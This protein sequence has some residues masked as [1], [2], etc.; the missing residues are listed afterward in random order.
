[1][2]QLLLFVSLLTLGSS[3]HANNIQISNVSLAS[4]NTTQGFYIIEFDL[5]WEN[6][7]RTST[8]ESNW[9]AAW[10]YVKFTPKNERNWQHA[11]LHY[12]NG[13]NDGHSVPAGATYRTANN[14]Y[15][16]TTRGVGVFIYRDAD[17]FGPVNFQNVQLRWDY[18]SNGL[19]AADVVEVSVQAIEMVYVRQGAFRLGDGLGDHGQFEAGNTGLPYT[20]NSESAITL[21]G[22]AIGNL[23][24]NNNVGMN[25]ADDFDY[26][27]TQT[28]PAAFPKGYNAFYCMKYE[29]SSGDYANFVSML[30]INSYTNRY[31]NC[32][33]Q[34][35]PLDAP[36]FPPGD[37][38]LAAD[39]PWRAV[40]CLSWGDVA[41][42][43]DWT[44]LRPMS[45]LEY[46]K[47]ARGPVEPVAG[48]LAWGNT[49]WSKN[50]TYTIEGEGPD[51]IIV[52]G[53]YE[54]VG[55][56]DPIGLLNGFQG[57]FTV[58][59]GIFA[60]SAINKT[61]QE[62]GASY[63]GIMEMT[64]NALEYVI[65]VGD[66]DT[67]DFTGR[68]GDGELQASSNASFSLLTDWAFVNADGI[69]YR[70]T[71]VS[72]REHANV[73]YMDR[74]EPWFGIRGCRTAP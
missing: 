70:E 24:N 1:M 53:L 17:G 69:G 74:S 67:R 19:G 27:T 73:G 3:L 9:D 41:A 12:V 16:T 15:G 6:S 22:T 43:L 39:H 60:A 62:T 8:Y 32:G 35:S 49:S 21:G 7:W 65:S 4:Q 44:G 37:G 26:L 55:N 58:R 33:S 45:E 61:R 23:S 11:H 42:Y 5:S 34:G 20:I 14:S 40:W 57:R 71:S 68:H 18:S 48:E 51:E 31:G 29:V 63:W 25:A 54:H 30:D 28:L 52:E 72:N 64:G 50:F 2:K 10:V 47:A 36:L 66:A 13:T 46:E 38:I 59:C 56:A